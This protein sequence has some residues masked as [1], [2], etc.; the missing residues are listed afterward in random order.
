MILAIDTA[1]SWIGLALHDGTDVPAEFGWRSRRTQTIELAPAVAQL[2]ERTGVSAAD[3]QAIAV[4]VGP[5]SYTGLRIGLALAKGIAL[6]HNLPL[7]GVPTLDIVAAAVRQLDTDLVVLAEAGRTRLWAGQYQWSKKTGW[8]PN[9]DPV[10]TSW[11]ELLSRLQVP[12]AFAGEITAASAK[13]IRRA[14]RSAHIVSP[15]GSVRRAAMLAEIG[16]QRLKTKKVSDAD[17]LAP[18]Y[19]REPG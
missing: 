10:L 6:G 14:N 3:L 17:T 12:V 18:L 5:G 9:D 2:W 7:I 8:E 13:L 1:T 15:A 19:L 4:A 11:D 16:Y